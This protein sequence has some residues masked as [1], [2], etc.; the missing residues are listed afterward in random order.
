MK[1]L[2][3]NGS[4]HARGNTYFAICAAAK[5]LEANGVEVEILHVGDKL[6]RGCLACGKCGEL[7]RCVIDDAVNENLDKILGADGLILASPVYFSGIAGTMKCYLDR[8]FEIASQKMRHKVGV[9][10]AV[11]RRSGGRSTVDSLSYFMSY[12]EMVIPSSRY[13]NIIHGTEPGEVEQD[14]EGQQTLRTLGRN[15]AWTL[16]SIALSRDRLD[17]PVEEEGVCFNFIH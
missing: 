11:A 15:L 3:V 1:V 4:P 17:L 5:E 9:G 13:W 14:L 10:I 6:I 2:A 7:G 12:C 8:T 16:K